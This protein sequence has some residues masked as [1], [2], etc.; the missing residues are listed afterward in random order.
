MRIPNA[1][2]IRRRTW[3]YRRDRRVLLALLTGAAN[4]SGWPITRTAQVSAARTYR[5]LDRL[6]DA[7]LVVG[8]WEARGDGRPRRRFYRLTPQGRQW[9][10]AQLGLE[11][12]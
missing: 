5:V 12:S 9:A 4:L 11:D 8:E 2:R 1:L 10:L 6:E 7:G 3:P